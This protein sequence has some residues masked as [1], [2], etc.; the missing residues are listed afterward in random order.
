MTDFHRN[1]FYY[2]KG[3]HQSQQE[4][5]RQLENNTTKSL[6][7]TLE[8]CNDPVAVM[9]LDWIGITATGRQIKFQLQKKTIGEQEMRGKSQRLLLGLAPTKEDDDPCAMLDGMATEGDSCPDAWLYGEDFVVL[10]ESKVIGSL[11][12]DQMRCHAHKLQGELEQQPKCEVRTWAEVHGFFKRLLDESGDKLSDRDKWILDQF[13]QYLEELGMS[14]FIGLEPEIFDYVVAPEDEDTRQ[15]VIGTIRSFA[16]KIMAQLRDISE[17]SFYEDYDVGK[18]QRGAEYC[19]VAFGPKDKAYRQWAHQT[20]TLDAKGI[21]VFVNVE[22]KSATDR[23]KKKLRLNGQTFRKVILGLLPNEPYSVR[24]EERKQRQA[25]IYDYNPIVTL[26]ACDLKDSHLGAP[27][28]SDIETLIER[29]SLP[30]L[31]IFRYPL[32]GVCQVD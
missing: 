27:G 12:P 25:S 7:N 17:L 11:D 2:Y 15:K 22:L 31:P 30:Y 23:L 21:E 13:T 18:F 8:Y 4:V 26:N 5:E 9:F 32:V 24:V 3:A 14:E 19:W 28:F 1:V 29:I 6:V 16:D 10:I 20:I